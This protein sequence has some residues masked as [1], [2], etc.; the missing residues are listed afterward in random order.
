MTVK[1]PMSKGQ[2][3][4]MNKLKEDTRENDEINDGV[5]FCRILL[6]MYTS[7][8]YRYNKPT[9]KIIAVASLLDLRI[10]YILQPS[11]T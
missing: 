8:M 2:R 5:Y 4:M 7:T 3:L 6:K 11:R 1:D 10:S 9:Q